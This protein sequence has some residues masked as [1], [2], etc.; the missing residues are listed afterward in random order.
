MSEEDGKQKGA[1]APYSNVEKKAPKNIAS[2]DETGIAGYAAH[3]WSASR[4][5]VVEQV[6]SEG[7]WGR[8]SW[9]QAS[10]TMLNIPEAPS[11]RH[12]GATEIPSSALRHLAKSKIT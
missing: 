8:Q 5:T 1:H 2:V 3:E 6:K 4:E 11:R 10:V 7:V 12:R 9:S